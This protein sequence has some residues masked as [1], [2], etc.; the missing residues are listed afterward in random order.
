M[1]A[2]YLYIYV[3]VSCDFYYSPTI[4]ES[5]ETS[6]FVTPLI[7]DLQHLVTYL[8]YIFSLRDK[9]NRAKRNIFSTLNCDAT[10]R[11]ILHTCVRTH[12]ATRWKEVRRKMMLQFARESSRNRAR[13]YPRNIRFT[14]RW[15]PMP[16]IKGREEFSFSRRSSVRSQWLSLSLLPLL[17]LSLP[18]SSSLHFRLLVISCCFCFS[19]TTARKRG[20]AAVAASLAIGRIEKRNATNVEAPTQRRPV[21]APHRK[22]SVDETLLTEFGKANLG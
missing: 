21:A 20:T 14:L 5:Y 9:K 22:S 17:T 7:Y 12:E 4:I 18:I 11:A 8:R 2:I 13:E 10:D 1:C 19:P 6:I 16:N 3:C 15:I